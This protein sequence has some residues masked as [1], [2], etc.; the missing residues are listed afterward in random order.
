MNDEIE[1]ILV[2]ITKTNFII[3]TP[4]NGRTPVYII[5]NLPSDN[6]I[7]NHIPLSICYDGKIIHCSIS[8][9]HLTIISQFDIERRKCMFNSIIERAFIRNARKVIVDP[10]DLHVIRVLNTDG[11]VCG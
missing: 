6:T 2:N 7:L 3:D 8:K 5:P 9:E 10:S 1:I 11:E 4:D